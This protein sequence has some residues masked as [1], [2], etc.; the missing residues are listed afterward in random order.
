MA[1]SQKLPTEL[2]LRQVPAFE[3][4]AS[5]DEWSSESKGYY[6]DRAVAEVKAVAA[7]WYGSNGKVVPTELYSDGKDLYQLTKIGMFTDEANQ[8]HENLVKS[9]KSKLTES[10]LELLGIKP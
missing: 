5:K 8:Y 6:R 2:N 4:I 9:I 3:V 1:K 10:E 7:G